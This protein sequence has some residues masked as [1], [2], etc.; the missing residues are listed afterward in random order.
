MMWLLPR[1]TIN[2]CKII[3]YYLDLMEESASSASLLPEELWT[4]AYI[5][6]AALCNSHIQIEGISRPLLADVVLYD[7]LTAGIE[8]LRHAITQSDKISTTHGRHGYRITYYGHY[9]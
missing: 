5:C 3:D 6:L 7:T 2:H 9:L 8:G 1:S 4:Q